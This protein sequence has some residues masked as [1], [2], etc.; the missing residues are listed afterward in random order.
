M[1]SMTSAGVNATEHACQYYVALVLVVDSEQ[2]HD[3]KLLNKM[4][5]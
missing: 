3:R 4:P 5:L 1:G 2:N